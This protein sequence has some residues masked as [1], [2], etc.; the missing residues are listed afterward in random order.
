MML[1]KKIKLLI[2]WCCRYSLTVKKDMYTVNQRIKIYQME[3][4][5]KTD[6]QL[7]MIALNQREADLLKAITAS[8]ILRKQRGYSLSDIRRLAKKYR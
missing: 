8:R 4:N 3:L 6:E 1:I 5:K 7:A 2:M